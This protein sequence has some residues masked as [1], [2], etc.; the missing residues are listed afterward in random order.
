MDWIAL[1]VH[2][3][4]IIR[5]NRLYIKIMKPHKTCLAC[6]KQLE[7]RTD[8]KFCDV[9]CKSAYHYKMLRQGSGNF[10][11]KV[12]KQLKK[13]RKLLKNYNKA[14][15]ATIRAQTLI[16]QGFDPNFFTHYWK[17]KSGNVYLFV[18]EFGFLTKMENGRK[19]FVL[20]TWQPYMERNKST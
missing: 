6:E 9:Y 13:N 15:K 4:Y 1:R 5:H 16:D 7:G 11:T 20:V 8:K 18:Y 19:K 12:D 14:G 3:A 17:N 2:Y 10:Y